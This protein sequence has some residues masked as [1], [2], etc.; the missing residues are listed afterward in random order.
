[1]TQVKYLKPREGKVRLLDQQLKEIRNCQH[2][3]FIN[4]NDLIKD[5]ELENNN[6][7]RQWPKGTICV[8]GDSIIQ[9]V[10]ERRLCKDGTMVKVRCF[11]SSNINDMYHF[12]LSTNARL[13]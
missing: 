2:I 7:E 10:D 13:S 12:V 6:D 8:K 3:R 1:M 5:D 11:P 4:K 9:G